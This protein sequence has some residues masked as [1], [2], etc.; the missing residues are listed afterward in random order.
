VACLG[1][2]ESIAPIIVKL[3]A[4]AWFA[5]TGHQAV[6]AHMARIAAGR[7]PDPQ[8]DVLR[9]IVSAVREKLA[10][11][12]DRLARWPSV[13]QEA[14][15]TVKSPV[16]TFLTISYDEDPEPPNALKDVVVGDRIR[17][18][19]AVSIGPSKS[20]RR[21]QELMARWRSITT[22]GA[23]SVS[24]LGELRLANRHTVATTQQFYGKAEDLTNL[25]VLQGSAALRFARDIARGG[26]EDGSEL[27]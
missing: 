10:T 24:G 20:G 1:W 15:Y 9:G 26:S 13:G 27:P 3:D 8:R 5:R 7:E 23:I 18:A 17:V 4:A 12:P 22:G 14:I 6:V 21:N 25:L 16:T 19:V 2:A 11:G